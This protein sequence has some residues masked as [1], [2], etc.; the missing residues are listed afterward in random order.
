[1]YKRT[2]ID[3]FTC[4]FEY[5]KILTLRYILQG[6]AWMDESIKNILKNRE[7]KHLGTQGLKSG[8]KLG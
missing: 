4:N 8:E 7:L 5:L 3:T 1:M 6:I 2:N